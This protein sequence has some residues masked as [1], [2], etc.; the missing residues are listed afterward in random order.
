[1]TVDDYGIKILKKA[2][3]SIPSGGKSDYY[4][5]IKGLGFLIQEPSFSRYYS[6]IL[7]Y[8]KRN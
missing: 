7:N 6:D 5:K 8:L 1:M 4:L 2:S 3:E